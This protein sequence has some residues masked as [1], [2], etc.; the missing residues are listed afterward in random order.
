[1]RE[2]ALVLL[3]V[4]LV[5]YFVINPDQLGPLVHWVTGIILR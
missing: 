2:W 5:L 3:P 4:A 1:M